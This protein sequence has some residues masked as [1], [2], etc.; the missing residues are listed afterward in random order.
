M[1]RL[2]VTVEKLKMLDEGSENDPDSEFE[3]VD[4]V[5][6]EE[7]E[8]SDLINDIKTH[9]EILRYRYETVIPKSIFALLNKK[10]VRPAAKVREPSP[11]VQYLIFSN[12]ASFLYYYRL[13]NGEMVV[14]TS[15]NPDCGLPLAEAKA[16]CTALCT[17]LLSTES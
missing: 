3:D 2:V 12:M 9:Y 1:N 6:G 11:L 14:Q 5:D 8:S 7:E 13:W 17:Q 15:E 10:K 16:V 4:V